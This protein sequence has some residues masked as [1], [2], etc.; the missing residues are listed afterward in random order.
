MADD[1]LESTIFE[2]INQMG[3]IEQFQNNPF[4]FIGEVFKHPELLSQIDALSKTPEMQQ[5]IA[6]SMA[7]PMFQQIVGN[8]PLLAGMMNDYK[9]HQAEAAQDDADEEDDEIEEEAGNVEGYDIT[10]PGWTA[11]DWLNPASNQPFYIPE[12]PE[13]RVHFAD[14]LADLPDECREPV[15]IIAEKRMQLHMSPDQ[16]A[17]VENIA[18]KYDLTALDLMA[19]V[20]GFIGEVCYCATLVMPDDDLCDLAKFAL[21]SLHRRS[22][23]PVA[24]YLT[25]ILLYLDSFDDIET[26]DWENFVW[27]LSGSPVA[28]RDGN[29]ALNWEDA[30]LI[31]EIA[32]DNLADNP[33][34]FLGVC[35]GMLGWNVLSLK[36][37]Q[38]PLQAMLQNASDGNA[39]RD[40]LLDALGG[41]KIYAL[42]LWNMRQDVRADALQYVITSGGLNML[43]EK[44][45][46]WPANCAGMAAML[47]DK[48]DLL[49]AKADDDKRDAFLMH[50]IDMDS[51]SLAQAA[52]RVGV[53]WKPEKYRLVALD[54]PYPRIQ[55][56]AENVGKSS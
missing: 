36:D 13:E 21:A 6:E 8:N 9:R 31:A 18:A 38:S 51:E 16:I 19:T 23:Y 10:I 34:L 29:F 52:L 20:G 4:A 39:I 12:K 47:V 15:E 56:W 41:R 5:Q 55:K 14:V 32:S 53:A 45:A 30:S 26:S 3:G 50:A 1:K 54:S 42:S 37:V 46:T 2:M 27:S 35:L 48:L 40:L 11:I 25:Q 43:L 44:A 33:E 49:W 7:N 28:G 17:H 24:S 22:G